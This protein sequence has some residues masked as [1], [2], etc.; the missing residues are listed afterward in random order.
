[1]DIDE[2]YVRRKQGQEL[3]VELRVI[4][5]MDGDGDQRGEN[6]IGYPE[7]GM[8][9]PAFGQELVMV[10]YFNHC[11]NWWVPLMSF[12]RSSS[13]VGH[14]KSWRRKVCLIMVSALWQSALS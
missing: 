6:I 10:R 5:V 12:L 4:D 11:C 14:T 3:P 2:D 13:V 8:I 7:Q 1:M 9:D